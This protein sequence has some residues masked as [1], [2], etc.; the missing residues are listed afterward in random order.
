M[1]K[2]K[3]KRRESQTTWKEGQLGNGIRISKETLMNLAKQAN[4]DVKEGQE[5]IVVDKRKSQPTA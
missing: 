5:E 2:D 4:W 1:G 3:K